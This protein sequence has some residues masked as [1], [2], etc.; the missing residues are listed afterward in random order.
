MSL[1]NQML[2]DL[3]QRRQAPTARLPAQLRAFPATSRPA[4]WRRYGVAGGLLAVLLAGALLWHPWRHRAVAKAAAPAVPVTR[5][6]APAPAV[7]SPKV[8]VATPQLAAPQSAV[9]QPAAIQP[10]VPQPVAPHLAI[11]DTGRMQA[12][13]TSPAALPARLPPV[14]RAAS[15]APAG[16]AGQSLTT[17]GSVSKAPGHHRHPA[18]GTPEGRPSRAARHRHPD[19]PVALPAAAAPAAV[20]LVPPVAIKQVSPQQQADADYLR[21]VDLLQNGHLADAENTLQAA[22][23]ID[24]GNVRARQLLVSLAVQAG[25][26]PHAEA[27]LADGLRSHPDQLPFV[28][29][30]ARLQVE[31]RAP[32][33]ALATLARGA[34]A[35]AHNAEYL[36]FR[37]TVLQTLGRHTEAIRFYRQA[38]ALAPQSGAWWMGLGLSLQANRQYAEARQAYL[39]AKQSGELSAGLLAFIDQ[40]LRQLPG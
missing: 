5:V 39:A 15:P 27:I 38:L 21:A 18:L 30:L 34:A 1:I 33:E 37:A 24:A 17:A 26:Y 28:I 11:P 10:T 2:E 6:V 4:A 16:R 9:A 19:R 22:L 29:M 31:R 40:K 13:A 14:T 20:R 12:A 23:L 25:N 35:G 32:A 8:A 36:A 7:P 3:E